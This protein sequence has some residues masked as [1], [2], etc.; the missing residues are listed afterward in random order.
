MATCRTAG[1]SS[2][3]RTVLALPE[4]LRTS[5]LSSA[6]SAAPL[7]VD[8]GRKMRMVVPSSGAP[9]TST[10]PRDLLH[11]AIHHAEAEPGALAA[12]LGREER[13]EHPLDDVGGMPVPVS[14]TDMT[15][16]LAG[17]IRRP[18]RSTRLSTAMVRSPP[19]GIAS[20]ALTA[21]FRRAASNWAR[22]TLDRHRRR[23]PSS[24]TLMCSPSVRRISSRSPGIS[25]AYIDG[26]YLQWLTRREKAS[27]R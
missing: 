22:S 6:G 16:I 12:L 13:L 24:S 17:P 20:R 8:R 5:R 14:L 21:R 19:S 10:W 4:R 23:P 3:T 7:L 26:R 2:T 25:A 27:N 15:M 18:P 1:L 9:S 11:E